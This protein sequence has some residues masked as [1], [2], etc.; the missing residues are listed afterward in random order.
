MKFLESLIYGFISGLTE[1]LPI[2]SSAHQIIVGTLFGSSEADPVRNMFVHISMLFALYLGT[3]KNR[4]RIYKASRVRLRSKSDVPKVIAEYRFLHF[5]TIPFLIAFFLLRYTL[6]ANTSLIL[7]S[8]CLFLNGVV[9]FLPERMLQGNK[10]AKIM[11]KLEAVLIGIAGALSALPGFSRVGLMHSV[12]SMRGAER[13]ASV[14][15]TLLLC[16]PALYAWIVLDVLALFSGSGA[17]FWRNLGYNLI[18]ALFAFWGT[19]AGIYILRRHIRNNGCTGYAF[20][21]WGAALL[22]LI[23]FL[24]IA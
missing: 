18:S 7:V 22:A 17:P 24:T 19:R 6:T 21:C 16:I 11:S 4:N 8:L 1:F 2:S 10:N 20:Y 23:L 15:W 13:K 3:A 14:N 12:S 9:I 5:A